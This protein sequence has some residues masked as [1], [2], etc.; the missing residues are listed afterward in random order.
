[1][2]NTRVA[3][4]IHILALI[5]S[6]PHDDL[7]SDYIASSVNTHP[8]VIRRILGMLRKADL[9]RTSAGKAGAALTSP[10]SEIS[11]FLVYRAVEPDNELFSV[12]ENPNPHCP[13][14]KRIN[15]VLDEA[16]HGAQAALEKKLASQ[17]IQDILDHLF[18]KD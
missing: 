18:Q 6:K 3:V 12:H 11:L 2:I 16:F 8:V 14:G 15:A 4:A 9:I 10:P 17:S 7:A 13:V 1:M 5:A